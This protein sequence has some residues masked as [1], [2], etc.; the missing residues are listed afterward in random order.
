MKARSENLLLLPALIL[1][2]GMILVGRLTAQTF[3]T[4]YSFTGGIQGGNSTAGLTLSGNT[5]YGTTDFGGQSGTVFKVNT[6]GTSYTNL[7]TFLDD[8]HG[9][10]PSAGL[11]LSSNLLYGTAQYSVGGS[12]GHGTVF[13]LQIDGKG[14]T[15]LHGF[16]NYA[17]N[18]PDGSYPVAGLIL[19]GTT[20]YGTV[21]EGGSAGNG[22]LFRVN[23]NGK[24]FTNLHSFTAKAGYA[25]SDGVD[26][27]GG[28]VLSGNTLYGTAYAGGSL[29]CGT[30]FAV[31][32][33]GTGFRT[34]HTFTNSDGANPYAGLIL[35]DNTLYG[36]AS[37]GGSSSVGTVFAVNTNG[38]GFTNLHSFGGYDG[39]LP[40]GGL[41]LSGNT[42]YGT[43]NR[44]GPNIQGTVF[45]INTDGTGFTNLYF[46]SYPFSGTNSDGAYPFGSL[47]FSDN[48]LYGTT[49]NGGSSGNGTVFSLF[50]PP[51]LT[52]IPAGANINLTWP[53]NATE[54]TLQSTAS[55]LSPV[56]WTTVS[57]GPVVVESQNSVTDPISTAQRF[58]RLS[59]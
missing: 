50:I 17:A 53:T 13:R 23:V 24:S 18:Y 10:G 20:L 33:D 49:Y 15:T 44:G 6:D 26:P 43:A 55:L 47:V 42:L 19:S 16:T 34:L 11:I 59:R 8:S 1:G 39:G 3:T 58:Y 12:A 51:Q 35:S 32:T 37:Q 31:N 30:V 36:T 46:F 5:L 25:N 22:T 57:P 48:T 2:L 28:L 21:T 41:V 56:V 14:I 4:L 52:I 38:S 9:F 40:L 45:A 7:Y 54:F 29:G 27:K